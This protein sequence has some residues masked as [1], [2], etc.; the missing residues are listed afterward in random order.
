MVDKTS[1]RYLKKLDATLQKINP[2]QGIY[3]HA[4][5]CLIGQTARVLQFR[6]A[7]QAS[8]GGSSPHAENSER[9]SEEQENIPIAGEEPQA[10]VSTKNV[11][12]TARKTKGKGNGLMHLLYAQMSF[13]FA[14]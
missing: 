4:L 8:I 1:L 2:T 11:K 9:P 12:K 10:P 7:T 5:L 14:I 6:L 3:A 13:R